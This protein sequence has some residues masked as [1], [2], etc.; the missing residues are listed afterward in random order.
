MVQNIEIDLGGLKIVGEDVEHWNY[1]PTGPDQRWGW[2]GLMLP[3]PRDAMLIVKMKDD[4][5]YLFEGEF[6]DLYADHLA[7]A[8]VPSLTRNFGPLPTELSANPELQPLE[9]IWSDL[10]AEHKQDLIV[11]A[12]R[13]AERDRT[14]LAK[15]VT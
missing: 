2:P 6:A 5:R 8:G 12:S 7:Q 15:I 9:Q 4:E 11:L 3:K 14:D 13:W 1:F 10:T